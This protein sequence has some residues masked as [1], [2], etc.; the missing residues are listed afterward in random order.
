M[1][2]R[3]AYGDPQY[4]D[5]SAVLQSGR[6]VRLD[7]FRVSRSLSYRLLF[8]LKSM[9]RSLDQASDER[10][11]Q[12]LIVSYKTALQSIARMYNRR[13]LDDPIRTISVWHCTVS[14]HAYHGPASIQRR[15][16]WQFQVQ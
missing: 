6:E 8:P 10:Q 5:Y 12:A 3:P 4:Y 15:L 2:T 16:F 1:Y 7:V 11:H 13:H 14:L 9:A